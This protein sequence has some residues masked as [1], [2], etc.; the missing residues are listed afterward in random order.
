MSDSELVELA[1]IGEARAQQ[2][3]PVDDMLRAWRIGVEVVIGY[4]REAG[5]QPA[6]S[7]AP[8]INESPRSSRLGRWFRLMHQ[9]HCG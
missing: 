9:P 1:A 7:L 5:Q 3:V 8:A 4:A 6:Q 2:G